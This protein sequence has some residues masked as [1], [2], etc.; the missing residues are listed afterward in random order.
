MI[1]SKIAAPIQE[2]QQIQVLQKQEPIRKED[3]K[4]KT[5]EK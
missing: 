1:K 3:Q 4:E 2:Q 5:G